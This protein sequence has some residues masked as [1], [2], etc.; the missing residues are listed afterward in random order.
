MKYL[1]TFEQND[2]DEPKV[3]D[4]VLC[5]DKCAND[6]TEEF[7]KENIGQIVNINFEHIPYKVQFE[8]PPNNDDFWGD[9][10]VK[11]R[12]FRWFFRSE[13]LYFESIKTDL[14]AILATRKY[15]L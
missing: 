1:K 12:V 3:G 5:I 2:L 6:K 10:D 9:D 8:N 4:Y 13:I 15:N 7:L 11:E 14:E